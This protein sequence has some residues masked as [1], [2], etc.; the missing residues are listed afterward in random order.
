MRGTGV[1]SLPVRVSVLTQDVQLLLCPW[2]VS[3]NNPL[4]P[5]GGRG[6]PQITLYSPRVVS[7]LFQRLTRHFHECV[8]DNFRVVRQCV[9]EPS[10]TAWLRQHVIERALRF[11]VS[12]RHSGG[13]IFCLWLPL[14]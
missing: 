11:R 12:T 4:L 6:F 5:S 9:Q 1:G 14:G 10:Q 7:Q 8:L 3:A 13:E 2:L